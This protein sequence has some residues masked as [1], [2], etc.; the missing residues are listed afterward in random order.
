MMTGPDF[1][2]KYSITGL[3]SMDH[4]RGA[5]V[6]FRI[7]KQSNDGEEFFA[8]VKRAAE[9]GYFRKYDVLILDN[10]AI[11]KECVERWLWENYAVFVLFLPTR[12]P[13]WNPIELVW[14]HLS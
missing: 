10:A 1:R 2:N 11:H 12:S 4:G 13:E 9:N 5:P 14:R 3:C 6:W 8:T 7:H